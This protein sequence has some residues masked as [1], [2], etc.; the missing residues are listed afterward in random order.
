MLLAEPL[1]GA[2][3]VPRPIDARE[4]PRRHKNPRVGFEIWIAGVVMAV[5]S[6]NPRQSRLSLERQRLEAIN[7]DS[8]YVRVEPIDLLPGRAPERYKVTF[9]CRGIV[10]IDPSQSPV[11]GVQ[12]EVQIYCDDDF[13]ADVPRLRWNTP[14]W[15]PN[16]QHEEPKN[17][18]VN[19]AEWLGGM[20]LNDLCQQLFEMVQYKNYHAELSP[21]YPLDAEAAT[22]VREYA[23]PRGVVNKNRG[24]SIDNRP[25]Y[26]PTVVEPVQRT[27][28]LLDSKPNASQSLKIKIQ[29]GVLPSNEQNQRVVLQAGAPALRC[30]TCGSE[31]PIDSQ[32]CDKCGARVASVVRRVRFR[33]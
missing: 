15:H 9:R 16:I 7:K 18:C 10:G 8:D 6:L 13:P 32:F 25:F 28:H 26:K 27:I 30:G 4:Q 33:N 24:V 1:S 11:Y 12:H 14:I 31:I 22:W 2:P 21:P 23:E 3:L 17:V 5:R 20:G 29:R 19:K